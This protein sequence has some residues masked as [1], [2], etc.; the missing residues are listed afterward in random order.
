MAILGL[1]LASSGA[2]SARIGPLVP[3]RVGEK[4]TYQI[5]WGPFVVGRASLEVAD[6]E[7]VDDH[8]CYHLIAKAKTSGLAEWL[9]PVD[10]TAESWLDCR[11]LFTRRYRQHRS[12]GKHV[13]NDETRY[14]YEHMEAI[15]KNKWG[16]KKRVPL[17]QPV[18]DVVS[19][20]YFVRAQKLMLDAEQTFVLNASDTNYVVTIRP[21][22]RK[23]IWLRP[24]GD[25]EAL[26]IEPNPTLKIVAANNGRLWFWV[27]DDERRLPLLVNSELRFGNAKLVLYSVASTTPS[28]ATTN[29]PAGATATTSASSRGGPLASGR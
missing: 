20:V 11:E 12:E 25:V 16:R 2:A 17:E 1:L 10:S 19:S 24:V 6:V 3:F 22:E 21:D 14:D 23:E 8:D 18:Q 29:G 5:F 28:S 7:K 15:T 26:R 9:F 4:L 13:T 27:S